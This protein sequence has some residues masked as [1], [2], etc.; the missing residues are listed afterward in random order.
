MKKYLAF[1]LCLM[2]ILSLISCN[3]TGTQIPDAEKAM[4]MYEA[5][6]ND[7]I[8]VFDEHL[9]EI[10][11]ESLRFT[12]NG[13][14]LA[15]CK[16]L[17]K[18]ISDIDQ[19]GVG[20]YVI[21]SPENDYII[22]RYYNGKVYSYRLEVSEFYKVNTDGTFYWYDSSETEEWACGLNKVVFDGETLNVKSLY[23]LQ[24]SKNPTKYEYFVE[25]E[26]VTEEDYYDYRNQ[27]ICHEG[28]NFSQFEL[29]CSYPIT[30]EQ[31]WNLA[32]TYWDNQDGSADAGA[33]TTW[34]TRIVLTD[35]PNSDFDYYRVALQEEWNS[36]GGQEGHECMPPYNVQLKAQIFVNAFT[37]EILSQAEMAMEAYESALKNEIKVYE[38]DIEEWNY[39]KDC[40]TPYNRIP[41]CGLESIGYVYMDVDGDS[42]NELVIDCGDTLILRY[43]E[44]TVYVYPFTF[45]N[46]YQLNTDG[47]YNWNHTGQDFEYGENQLV[48]DGAELNPKE[49]WRIVNGGAPN[50]EYYIDGKRVSHEDLLKYCEDNPKTKVTF[51]PFELSAESGMSHEQA[52]KI[53]DKYWG[54]VDGATDAAC[55]TTRLSRVV[56]SNAPDP[57]FHYYRIVWQIEYYFNCEAE[58]YEDGRPYHIETY[59]EVLVNTYTGEC[60][61]CVEPEHAGNV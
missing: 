54:C 10:K 20:E 23:S 14:S 28:M 34:I 55:G 30:A 2:T 57:N 46:M 8:C 11:L 17:M 56:I 41:L 49:I 21:K 48:F 51:S 31:A 25:G 15:E 3:N 50:A 45:R 52:L 32:N 61:A 59:R 16:L 13:A 18:A 4:Q 44:G 58:G 1:L 40:K 26:T 35:T 36:G 9:G 47:S 37:G 7:E 42:I 24:Y 29:K 19:D 38:T 22:L 33:G 6:I 43:Y 27:N 53:A 12:S 5:A 60:S 39:L